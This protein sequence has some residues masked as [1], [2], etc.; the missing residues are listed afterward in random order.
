MEIDQDALFK[1]TSNVAISTKDLL[2]WIF[3]EPK[4]SSDEPVSESAGCPTT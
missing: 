4:Y 2:S 3:D 1:P